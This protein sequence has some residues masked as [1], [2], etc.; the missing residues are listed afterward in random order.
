MIRRI[1]F[2]N[3]M[4]LRHASIDREP[5]TVFIGANGSGKSAIFKGLVILSK[6][7][8]GQPIRGKKGE[9]HL[10]GVTL[11]NIVWKGNSGLPIVFRVWFEDDLLDPGYSLELRRKAQGWSVTRERR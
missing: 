5:L 6:L 9:V 1:E 10:E 8:N 7:L 2:E 4:S 11:D 3:F